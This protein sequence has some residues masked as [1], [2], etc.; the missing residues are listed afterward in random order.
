MNQSADLTAILNNL[1]PEQQ[2][3]LFQQLR[4]R[5]TIHPLEQQWNISAEFILEAI[6]QSQD[7]TKRGVRG[8]IAELCFNTYILGAMQQRGWT[9]HPQVGDLPYDALISHPNVGHIKIQT[10]NQRLERGVPK[11]ANT[12]MIRFNPAVDGWFVC[13]TQKTRTG[14]DNEGQDTRPYRYGEFDILSV[15]LHPSSGD[16][17]QFMFCPAHTLI[18]RADNP[19]LIAVL[20][21]VAPTRQANWTNNLEEAIQWHLERK[22]FN[23]G[24]IGSLI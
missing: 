13:E 14:K 23:P 3:A 22:Q 7:I 15:C 12:P 16:W 19:A 2:Q 21:P 1:P 8:I 18:P 10:K 17:T 20:Q 9:H 4:Q 24:N 5:F 6:S 11:Y